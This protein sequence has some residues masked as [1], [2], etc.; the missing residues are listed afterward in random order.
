M[1]TAW[2]LFFIFILWL[3]YAHYFKPYY[4]IRRRVCL[5]GPSPKVYVG[6]YSE[7]EK[8]GYLECVGKWISQYRPTF[9]CYFGIKPVIMTEDLEIIKSVMVKNFDCFVN[10]L[11]TPTLLHLDLKFQSDETNTFL[12]MAV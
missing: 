3:V 10:R 6:N 7:I 8:S 12:Y 1:V 9:I 5:P 11:S 4:V 2:L